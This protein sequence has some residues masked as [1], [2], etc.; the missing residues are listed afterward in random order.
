MNDA[1]LTKLTTKLS[2]AC[3]GQNPA[4][5][6]GASLQMVKN[7]CLYEPRLRLPTAEYLRQFADTLDAP[8]DKVG[9]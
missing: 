5:I 8:T 6:V 2:K 1:T 7:M 9:H 3:N 4:E